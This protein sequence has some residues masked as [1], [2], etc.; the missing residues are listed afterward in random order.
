MEN[1]HLHQELE[2]TQMD[3]Y[4]GTGLGDV[5]EILASV[6]SE[7]ILSL[8]FQL[9][10]S[11]ED[12][13]INALCLII[14][15]KAEKALDILHML[16]ENDLAKLLTQIWHESGCKLENFAQLCGKSSHLTGESLATLARVFK[17]LSEHRL[18]DQLLRNEAYK[19]ALS[20]HSEK[21]DDPL[22]HQL[23]E[24]AKDLCGPQLALWL[25]STKNL[26]SGSYDQTQNNQQTQNSGLS[27]LL[28]SSSSELSYP[29]HLE[30]SLPSTILYKED[31]IIPNPLVDLEQNDSNQ[32]PQ[33]HLSSQAP[34]NQAED[35]K[36]A[37]TSETEDGEPPKSEFHQKPEE[38]FEQNPTL[39]KPS[40]P[41]SSNQDCPTK[42]NLSKQTIEEE[43]EVVFY[44]FVIFHA[45]EDSE[46]AETMKDKVDNIIGQGQGAT[47]SDFEVPGKSTLKCI[48]DAINNSAFTFL[49]LTR[50][51]NTHM[52]EWKTESALINSINKQ[53]K[54]NTV[55]PL[56]PKEN[57]MTRF[58]LPMVLQTLVSLEENKNFEVKIK[59]T[60]SPAI[61]NRQKNIWSEERRRRDQSGLLPQGS[62]QH[63][64]GNLNFKDSADFS[65]KGSVFGQ[66]GNIHIENANYVMIGNDSQMTVDH[67]G[68][69]ER[70][71]HTLEKEG[72]S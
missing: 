35:P 44:S 32:P 50:N 39:T 51:F 55:I 70:P 11:P 26:Q 46:M 72:S 23:Q 67:C 43:D 68:V 53:H 34:S 71:I 38:S 47:Y 1:N 12:N 28:E 29:S 69:V 62:V 27:S 60:L 45:Q 14:L 56:F 20:S 54:N 42:P 17:I 65:N 52:L 48:E 2:M 40:M 21:P 13:I 36:M 61:I 15:H 8:T 25:C 18:C 9:E 31:K 33:S 66:Q 19:K 24:E 37:A 64:L 30:I 5:Y 22:Y 57:A 6:P 41:F 58:N 3:Q 59:K 49:L 7:R 10:Q 4:K 63:M 16:E